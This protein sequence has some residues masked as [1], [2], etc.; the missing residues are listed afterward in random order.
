MIRWVGWMVMGPIVV[1][2]GL[3]WWADARRMHSVIMRVQV[4]PE[5]VP[6]DGISSARVTVR[7]FDEAGRP[8]AGDVI[9]MLNTGPGILDRFRAQTDNQGMAGFTFTSA[10]SNAYRPAGPVTL[11]VTNTSIGRVIEVTKTAL[12]VIKTVEPTP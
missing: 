3:G 6:A 1:V 10:H 8:R 11:I 7:V 12:A 5:R 2:L 9:E 4:S